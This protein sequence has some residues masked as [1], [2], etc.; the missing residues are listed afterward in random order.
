M[1]KKLLSLREAGQYL[2]VSQSLLY[3]LVETKQIPHLRIG[4]KILFDLKKLERFIE[5]N[6]IEVQDWSEKVEELF[7]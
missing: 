2:N 6:S 3:K 5:L 1:E 7:K 4:R